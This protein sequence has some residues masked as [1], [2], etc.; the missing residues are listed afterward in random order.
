MKIISRELEI[1]VKSMIYA[2]IVDPGA[3]NTQKFMGN[4]FKFKMIY[5]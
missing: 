1:Y 4:P 2:K 3:K 5:K